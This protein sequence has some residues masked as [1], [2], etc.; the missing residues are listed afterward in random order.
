MKTWLC[1]GIVLAMAVLI[2]CGAPSVAVE[3][4]ALVA[5]AFSAQDRV[6][7][8][9]VD[10]SATAFRGDF[11]DDPPS[12]DA[13]RQTLQTTYAQKLVAGLRERGFDAAL[14]TGDPG[15]EAGAV[16][17]T[18]KPT[19][20]DAGSNAARMMVGM[21]AGASYLQTD[22]IL[23]KDGRTV[24]DFGLDASSGG[25]GGVFALGN[26]LDTHIDDSV[27]QFVEYFADRLKQE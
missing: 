7:V 5:G 19:M 11:S 3:R 21:G 18:L 8:K 13:G 24:A 2:G 9:P 17:V 6:L 25:R 12:V 26:W 20:F 16:V 4:T 27:S 14:H 23:A 10:A 22:V 15:T 1:S